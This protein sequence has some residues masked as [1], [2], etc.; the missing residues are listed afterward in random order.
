MVANMI[1]SYDMRQGVCCCAQA[2]PHGKKKKKSLG[3]E[4]GTFWHGRVLSHLPYGNPA[5]HQR[6]FDS[7][8]SPGAHHAARIIIYGS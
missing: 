7:V 6:G 2:I 5:K 8:M 1:R 3:R 4:F